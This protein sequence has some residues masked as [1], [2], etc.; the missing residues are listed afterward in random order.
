MRK[1][2]LAVFVVFFLSA[3]VHVSAMI[4]YDDED[5]VEAQSHYSSLK[6]CYLKY[7]AIST[8]LI[9]VGGGGPSSIGR[10]GPSS[11]GRGGL[12]SVNIGRG[13]PSSIGRGGLSCLGTDGDIVVIPVKQKELE[14]GSQFDL[15]GREK[16]WLIFVGVGVGVRENEWDEFLKTEIK[17]L[18]IFSG[19]PMGSKIIRSDGGVSFG[20]FEIHK[21]SITFTFTHITESVPRSVEYND[22]Y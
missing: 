16:G 10:G 9:R 21:S 18:E 22:N 2:V 15:Y 20:A 6:S 5:F 1:V 7:E 12:S 17:E 14:I 11:I 4:Y 3:H 19:N 13:G 8:E